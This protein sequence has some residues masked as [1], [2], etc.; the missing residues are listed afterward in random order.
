[1]RNRSARAEGLLV[2]GLVAGVLAAVLSAAAGAG[3]AGAAATS[4]QTAQ[5]KKALLVLSDLP[6]GWTSSPSP[7]TGAGSFTGAP[8]L[9]RCLGV[10]RQI[11]A[12][13]PPE[14]N[15]ARLSNQGGTLQVQ[16]SI[17][18]YPSAKFAEEEYDAV[19]SRAAPGCLH[20]LLNSTLSSG[21]AGGSGSGAAAHSLSVTKTA[22]PK[23]TTAFD[24]DTAVTGQGASVPVRLELVF[25]VRGELGDALEFSSLGSSGLTPS[26]VQHLTALALSRL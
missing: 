7:G 26:L 20:T 19:S 21:L 10:P 3:L 9:A 25:F 18:I 22:S 11:V 14:I 23:G 12:F 5:A 16:D 6:A 4:A 24:L 8:Q 2:A 15:S 17:S 13:L 1:V